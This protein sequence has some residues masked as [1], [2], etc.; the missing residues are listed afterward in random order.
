MLHRHGQPNGTLTLTSDSEH[1][2]KFRWQV[3]SDL[4]RPC[5]TAQIWRP[6]QAGHKSN[7]AWVSVDRYGGVYLI[8][9]HPQC[10]QRG[11]FNKRLLGQAP[12]SLLNLHGAAAGDTQRSTTASTGSA[13]PH[14]KQTA[15]CIGH[16]ASAPMSTEPCQHQDDGE[17]QVDVNCPAIL[18]YP[19]D[20]QHRKLSR[21]QSQTQVANENQR[22]ENESFQAWSVE[23]GQWGGRVTDVPV[24][25]SPTSNT[26][27]EPRVTTAATLLDWVAS[28]EASPFTMHPPDLLINS[29]QTVLLQDNAH[30][31]RE[32][33]QA[34]RNDLTTAQPVSR[35]DAKERGDEDRG[36]SIGPSQ[37]WLQSPIATRPSV[38]HDLLSQA[39]LAIRTGVTESLSCPFRTDTWSSPFTVGY[40]NVGRRHLVGSL[41]EVA[42][43]VLK[44]R[45]DI[46]FLGD[47][48]TS[49][50]HIG[51][52]KKQLESD[53]HDEWFGTT[54][55]SDQPGRPVG[56]GA[57]VHCSLANHMSDCVLQY[58]YV[59]ESDI[60]KQSW[61]DA[62]DGRIQR[63]K[64]TRPGSPF[65]WQFVGVYQHVARSSNRTARTLVR[66]TLRGMVDMAREDGCRM[67]ILGDFNAAPP[68][69]RWGYSRW[70]AAAREDRTMTD[71]MRTANLTEVLPR[72]KLIPT[73]KPSEGPQKAVLDRVL[74]THDDLASLE[75][76]VRWHRPLIVFDHALLTLQIQH[77]LIGTG[78]GGACRPEREAPTRSRCRVDLRRWRG[79]ISEWSHLVHEGLKVMS[80][81]HQEHP[82]DPFE[83][84]KRGELLADSIAQA[85][86]PKH[87][88]KPGDTRRAFGFA[89]NRLLFRELNLLRKARSIVFEVFTG[90]A[91]VLHCPHR[92]VRWTLATRGLHLRVRRSGHAVPE[93][94]DQPA[95]TY[96]YPAARERLRTW[97]EATK[98]MIAS[99]Q[100][101]VR[102]SYEKA[103]YHNLQNL[104][105]KQKE[106]NGVLDKRTI[107]AAL[108]KCQPRQRMWAVSG[109]VI[110]GA[111]IE[112]PV[113]VSN[114][115]WRCWNSLQGCMRRKRLYTCPAMSKEWLS[116]LVDRVKRVILW[117]VG[118]Q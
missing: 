20:Q 21:E 41:Q 39:T 72:G 7:G 101:E 78:Y 71:W 44:H 34:R 75:L 25:T 53:L 26:R 97:L 108:G 36:W 103:R 58:P 35:G 102:E 68:G 117:F 45:P 3:P 29:I 40:L 32:H 47:L 23:T 65:T 61:M 84:L 22:V 76:S 17:S 104:R 64:I 6:S 33:A 5:L 98:K 83:H 111:K 73:W 80:A 63:I 42:E 94:L 86:A 13:A 49:R 115:N 1:D 74:V 30:H 118:N 27:P 28:S 100:A 12:L 54:N 67:A 11:Y 59:L 10:L 8:C 96:F 93:P 77:S 16:R 110:L 92:L 62:V 43:L 90:V 52:L 87:V 95:H 56:I 50:D 57:I 82:L 19:R 116:G 18:E 81:E 109:T 114:D 88:W 99:R 24:A 91:A 105:K 48:V 37:A 9:L 46:L 107:Q 106:A 89:G 38:G 79:R 85:L 55:I 112:V 66:D 4:L 14:P 70:S 51:R 60:E 2:I 69:G 113:E 15:R 31:A